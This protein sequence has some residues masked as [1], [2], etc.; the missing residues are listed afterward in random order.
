MMLID[1]HSH[2][3]PSVDDGSVDMESSIELA[4][5]ACEQDIRHM[6]VTPHHMDGKYIN[7][8]QDIVDKTCEFQEKLQSLNVNLDV[9]PSQEV[10]LSDDLTPAIEI[11]DVLFMDNAKRY[12]LLELPHDNV[13]SYTKKMIFELRT[14]KI[15]PV[16][17][18][19]E[20]NLD[21]QKCPDKLY[22]LIEMGCL[23]QLT[24]SSYLGI[25][26]KKVQVLTE[27]FIKANLGFVLASDAHNLT[28]RRFLMKEAFEKL[29]SE[30]GK[31][32][33]EMFNTNAKNII[34]GD[35]I[36]DVD[37]KRVSELNKKNKFWLFKK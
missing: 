4:R 30:E 23:S 24:S 14:K 37:Y 32:K 27:K 33:A 7:H 31:V 18:H 16:I 21:I 12:L 3:L 1:L 6:L 10:H 22:E 11:D 2:I 15:I 13:P 29:A 35:E 25:F 17:A 20:R 9:Y 8:R 36:A 34:N 5:A 28:G 26:G 19:P